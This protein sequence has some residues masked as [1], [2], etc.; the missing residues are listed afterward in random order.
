MTEENIEN[1]GNVSIKRKE[2][3]LKEQVYLKE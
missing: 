3:V 1:K 2:R